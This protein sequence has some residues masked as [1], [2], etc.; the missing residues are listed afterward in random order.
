MSH[1]NGKTEEFVRLLTANQ[2]RIYAFILIL[3]PH[4]PD[5]DDILQETSAIMWR[6]FSE[7]RLGSDF[8]AW[9]MHIARNKIMEYRRNQASRSIRFGEMTSDIIVEECLQNSSLLQFKID[10]LQQCMSRLNEEDRKLV[11]A[12]YEQNFTIKELAGKLNRPGYTLYRML[13]RIHDLLIRCMR[14]HMAVEGLK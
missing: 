12:R 2:H 3:V 11:R 5:A 13:G 9:G 10:S 1:D 8:T 4:T 7:F 14:R 6:K